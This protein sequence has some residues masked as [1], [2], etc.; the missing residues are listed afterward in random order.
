[1]ML[2]VWVAS[3]QD[4]NRLSCGE[5]MERKLKS[6]SRGRGEGRRRGSRFPH[7]VPLEAYSQA[8]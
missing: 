8:G 7:Y 5:E 2:T 4:V 3:E 6:A 1:M